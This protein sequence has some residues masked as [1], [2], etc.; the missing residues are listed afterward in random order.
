MGEEPILSP[1][2]EAANGSHR[3]KVPVVEFL[4]CVQ[5]QVVSKAKACV[6]NT[7]INAYSACSVKVFLKRSK[8][9][10]DD[11]DDDI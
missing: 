3:L 8:N 7:S 4:T 6:Q 2:P 1:H 10:D 5:K 9:D 11:D